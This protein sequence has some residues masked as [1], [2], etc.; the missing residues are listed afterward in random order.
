MEQIVDVPV[1]QGV[2]E[3]VSATL[4]ELTA[5]APADELAPDVELDDARQRIRLRRVFDAG[6]AERTA[7]ELFQEEDAAPK[8]ATASLIANTA[9][10]GKHKK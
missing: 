5:A 1:P 6:L 8:S 7:Q 9:K 2:K 4:D 3:V 10:K